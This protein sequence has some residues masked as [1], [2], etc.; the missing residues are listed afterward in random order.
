MTSRWIRTALAAFL[1][2]SGALAANL[3]FLQPPSNGSRLGATAPLSGEGEKSA[4]AAGAWSLELATRAADPAGAS[5]WQNRGAS[6]EL[7]RAV[8]RELQAKGYETGTV[9]GVPGL[10]TRAAIMAYEADRGLAL[11]GEPAEALLERLVLGD[12]KEETPSAGPVAEPGPQAEIV[13]RTVERALLALG[14]APGAVDGRLSEATI[15]AIRNF[16]AQQKMPESG[17]ISGQLVARLAR[18][19]GQGNLAETR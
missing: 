3:F 18:I 14:L 17:R 6:A 4:G 19:A 16:E 2:L 13:I 12:A 8:Q 11:T 15:R 9:D 10:V 7:T 5:S 1:V